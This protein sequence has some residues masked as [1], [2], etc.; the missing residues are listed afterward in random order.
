MPRKHE[1]ITSK[2]FRAADF[3]EGWTLTA[4]IELAR[5]ENVG[6]GNDAKQKLVVYFR[7]QK[8]GLVCGSVLWDQF[9][10]LTGEENSDNWPGHMAELFRT[11]TPFGRE[12]MPCIRARKPGAPKKP[13]KAA[14]K[15]AEFSDEVPC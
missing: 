12:I 9:I 3:P 5:L 6:Q 13:R 1:V 11:T 10:E 8:P 4:E 2:Y 7:R 15:P 14:S